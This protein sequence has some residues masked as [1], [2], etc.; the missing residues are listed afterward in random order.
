[1]LPLE[2]LKSVGLQPIK[3]YS[4]SLAGK[5]PPIIEGLTG[6]QRLFYGW[7]QVWQIKIRTEAAIQRIATDPHSPGEVRC[8]AVV[9]NV[10]EFYEAF[11]V[12]ESDQL[13]LEP[14]QRVRIW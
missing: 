2:I 6:M 12:K 7:A 9:R 8:N 14:A 3:A 4:I 11:G 5:E 13:F 1:M 10:A